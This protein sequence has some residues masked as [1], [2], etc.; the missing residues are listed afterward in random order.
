MINFFKFFVFILIPIIFIISILGIVSFAAESNSA[1]LLVHFTGESTMGEQVYFSVSKDGL[2]WTEIYN[3]SP[4]LISDVG[5]NGVR[6]M[7]SYVLMMEV[8]FI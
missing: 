4:V 7:A 2:N 3:T 5:E 1:Y 6:D 8:N